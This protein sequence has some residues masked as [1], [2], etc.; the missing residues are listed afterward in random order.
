MRGVRIRAVIALGAVLCIGVGGTYAFWSDSVPVDGVTVTSGTLDLQVNGQDAIPDYT[1]LNLTDMVP[2]DST[3]AVL[4]VTNNGNVPFTY[5]ADSTASGDLG[6]ALVVKVTGDSSVTGTGHAETCAGAALA[7]TGTSFG[8]N[9][10]DSA[11]PRPL[12]P[13]QSE[14]ICIQATLPTNAPSSLQG[15]STDITLTFNA[16]QAQ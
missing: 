9:L 5:F 3:A 6:N 10:I 2:G 11:D 13:G 16:N 14:T 7:N 15:D 4:T 8:P 1:G 12:D